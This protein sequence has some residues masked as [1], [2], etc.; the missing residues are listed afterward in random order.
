M[1]ANIFVPNDYYTI[2]CN[3]VVQS[4]EGP[5]AGGASYISVTGSSAGAV[6]A[7]QSGDVKVVFGNAS[8]PGA[9]STGKDT[10]WTWD[11]ANSQLNVIKG[12]LFLITF[13][14][15][16]NATGLNNQIAIADSA[17]PTNFYPMTTPSAVAAF[18]GV[19]SFSRITRLANDS[20]FS[21]IVRNFSSAGTTNIYTC[22]FSLTQ[23][24]A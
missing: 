12:G 14:Y 1:S 4:G 8:T 11:A 7:P 22:N 23:L 3:K 6:L 9:D 15:Y 13:N 18:S 16:V 10:N 20:T 21:F 2:Y 17:E 5:P 24:G 19:L